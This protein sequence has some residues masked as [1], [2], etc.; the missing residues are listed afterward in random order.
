MPE[1]VYSFYDQ[2]VP[3]NIPGKLMAE[4]DFTDQLGRL[5]TTMN[6]ITC[7]LGIAAMF[8]LLTK[9]KHALIPS[10]IFGSSYFFCV[11][12]LTKIHFSTVG[13]NYREEC[14][15]SGS[16]FHSSFGPKWRITRPGA[17]L[18]SDNWEVVNGKIELIAK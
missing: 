9:Y 13:M 17:V 15:S 14:E 2:R 12:K 18:R 5:F 4:L 1:Y 6:G 11:Y 3:Q 16:W 10:V 8:P 7:F